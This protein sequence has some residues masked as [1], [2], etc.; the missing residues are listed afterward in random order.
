M[1]DVNSVEDLIESLEGITPNNAAIRVFNVLFPF[2]KPMPAEKGDEIAAA[3]FYGEEE[4]EEVIAMK[5]VF[6]S[7][8]I[9]R[10]SCRERVSSPV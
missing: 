3:E 7:P 1:E 2:L 4:S 6:A 5:K 10:A 9:G 8:E